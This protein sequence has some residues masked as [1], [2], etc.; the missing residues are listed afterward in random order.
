MDNFTYW[1]PTKLIF[2]KGQLEQLKVEVPQYGKKVL[3]VYGGGSIK[4]NGLYDQVV[5]NLEEIG[6]QVFELS[7][8]EPNPRISTVRKG[9]DLCKKEQIDFLLAVGG[10]SVI[11]CT[12]AIAAG[13][14]YDGDAWDLVTK[15]AFAKEAL[16]FGTILTIAATGSE[17]N[18]GSV[19]TNWETNEKYGWGSSVTFP[20]F[21]ILD[22]VNTMTV[23]KDQTVYGMVDM[24]SHVFEH[25]FHLTENT[26]MQDRMCESLLLTVMETAPKL[27]NDLENYEYR[28]T[29]LYT[30]TM[31]LNG[32][33]SM[34]Y[35][36]DWASHNIEHAVSAVYDIPHGGGLAILFPNWMKHNLKVKPSRFKQLAVRV[37]GVDPEGKTD[38]EAGLEGIEKLREF[39]NSIGAPS[40]LSDYNIDASKLEVMADKA[41]A[42]GEFGNFKKLNREDVLEIYRKSL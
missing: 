34:G 26:L 12:K 8:V 42:N 16:P 31:A 29:I 13:A 33:L 15:K 32:M 22:P 30:G 1:N 38:E 19:I 25:Y 14:K 4:K 39:W 36:G 3:L 41:M 2:G 23:P 37:F 18:A 17:M 24:M 6:S 20:K 27:I 7:G 35:R 10:G 9:V 28:S 5:K 40:R 11:D 21:S